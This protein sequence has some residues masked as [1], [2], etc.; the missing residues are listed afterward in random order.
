MKIRTHTYI[1]MVE[2]L[3]Y[4][5]LYDNPIACHLRRTRVDLLGINR[6]ASSKTLTT[7]QKR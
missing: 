5:F 7:K 2:V 4:T 6:W 3:E 1:I